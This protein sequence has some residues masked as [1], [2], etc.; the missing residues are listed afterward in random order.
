MPVRRHLNLVEHN[1]DGMQPCRRIARNSITSQLGHR[2]PSPSDI[3]RRKPGPDLELPS[4]LQYLG[5]VHSHDSFDNEIHE[6][7]V[8]PKYWGLG[9]VTAGSSSS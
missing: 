7:A 9:W 1:E 6:L 4:P 2:V 8:F 3:I 5:G